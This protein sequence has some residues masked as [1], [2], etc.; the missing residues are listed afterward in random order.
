MNKGTRI[1]FDGDVPPNRHKKLG[2]DLD[3]VSC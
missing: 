1:A 2:G 3:E